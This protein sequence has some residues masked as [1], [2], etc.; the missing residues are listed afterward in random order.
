M[1]NYILSLSGISDYDA[2]CLPTW[3]IHYIQEIRY[4]Y[5][6]ALKADGVI[7]IYMFHYWGLVMKTLT[8]IIIIIKFMWTAMCFKISEYR[9]LN[10][11]AL[12][13]LPQ[14]SITLQLLR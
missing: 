3:Q 12:S 2:T 9:G 5:T 6:L 13:N 4:P 10:I 14:R 11:G 1:R 8:N 7:F